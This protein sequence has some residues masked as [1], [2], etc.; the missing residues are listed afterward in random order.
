MFVIVKIFK[1][2][3]VES[4]SFENFITAQKYILSASVA[5]LPG[6]ASSFHLKN[7][8]WCGTKRINMTQSHIDSLVNTSH[9]SLKIFLEGF[10]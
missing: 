7:G 2:E 5:L 3:V 9:N 8:L 1:G 4:L 6:M 10:P